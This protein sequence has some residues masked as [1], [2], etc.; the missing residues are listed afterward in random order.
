MPTEFLQSSPVHLQLWC[1]YKPPVD[2]ITVQILTLE[3]WGGTELLAGLWTGERSPSS[4]G[5]TIIIYWDLSTP[6]CLGRLPGSLCHSANMVPSTM[7]PLHS[8]RASGCGPCPL[9]QRLQLHVPP[10]PAEVPWL[11]AALPEYWEVGLKG[12]CQFHQKQFNYVFILVGF[13]VTE[14]RELKTSL[15]EWAV[16]WLGRSRG[17][18]ESRTNRGLESDILR[19][20]PALVLQVCDLEQVN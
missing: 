15:E 1:S 2:L 18:L 9:C 11:W 5:S 4:C 3:V 19:L 16:F 13:C 12:V 17:G 10:L 8:V 20:H 7:V 6:W 14:E